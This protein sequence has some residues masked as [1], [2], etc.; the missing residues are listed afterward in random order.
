MPG[1]VKLWWH[2]GSTLDVRSH[3]TPLIAEPELG[4]ETL[5]VSTAAAVASGAAPEDAHVAVIESGVNLRYRV[6]K[7]GQNGSAADPEAKPLI[8]TLP[9]IAAIGIAPGATLS[10]IEEA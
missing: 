2:D 3:P 1:T 7:P 10:L 8:A 9:G 4:F 5:S 6:L